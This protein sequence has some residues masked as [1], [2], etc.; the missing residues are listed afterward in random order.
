MPVKFV[1]NNLRNKIL[2][3]KTRQVVAAAAKNARVVVAETVCFLISFFAI[4]RSNASSLI[5]E[6]SG[7]GD[8][9]RDAK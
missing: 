7:N 8:E 9:K 4:I 2:L 5:R 6:R 3:P 1:S